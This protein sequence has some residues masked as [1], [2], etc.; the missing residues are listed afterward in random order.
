M[1]AHLDELALEALASGRPELASSEARAH[2]DGCEGCQALVERER[3]M[4]EDAS[5]GLRRA[6]PDLPGLDAMIARAMEAAPP[7]AAPSRRSLWVG[8]ALGVSAAL[9]MGW[10]SLPRASLSDAGTFGRQ[11]LTLG[12]AVDAIVEASVPGGWLAIAGIGLALALALALPVRL[13]LGGDRRAPAGAIARLL[14][15]ALSAPA[16]TARAYR[17][18][19]EWPDRRIS[20]D[21]DERPTSEALRMATEAAGL[22]LV[23]RFPSDPPVTLHVRDVPIGEVVQA[24]LGDADVVVIAGERLVTV[25]ADSRENV[26]VA[27]PLEPPTEPAAAPAEPEV[28]AGLDDRVTFGGDVTI[29]AGERVRDVVTMGGDA[30]VEGRAYGDVVTMGGDADIGGQVV[31]DVITMGGDIRVREGAEVHGALNAMGGEVEVDDGARV[32]GQVRS[33]RDPEAHEDSDSIF[34]SGLWHA[35]L[36]LIGLAMLGTMREQLGYLRAELDARPVRS[37]FGGFFVFLAAAI[38][39]LVL[40]VT[41]IGIP[42]ALILG[43]VF[44]VAMLI[45]WTTSAL[46]LGSVLPI[47][48]LK[49]RPVHQLGAGIFLLFVLG[50]I[51]SVG[52]LVSA[53]A[54][55][56]GLGAVTATRFGSAP[57]KKRLPTTGPFR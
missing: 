3:A 32:H 44:V 18:E 26:A 42:V 7:A 5:V 40:C 55:L 17:V 1:S 30:R 48:A 49:D 22:G 21:V 6:M 19:G 43:V 23:A 14:A 8:G 34:R 16:F 10:L 54:L 41:I 24:L 9:V 29:G 20:L 28:P 36:F 25:R 4:L 27:A 50:E 35:L 11:A 31:G 51:P 2:H 47:K 12:R 46:W 52:W 56:A 38:L 13:F 57:R 33:E 37:G 39:G 53:A 15:V 45:G